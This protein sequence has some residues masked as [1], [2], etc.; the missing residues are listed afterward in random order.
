MDTTAPTFGLIVDPFIDFISCLLGVREVQAS[1]L[2][3]EVLFVLDHKARL[4][5]EALLGEQ[6][7][8]DQDGVLVGLGHQGLVQLLQHLV[9]TCAAD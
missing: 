7:V 6:A 4:H 9:R 3:F 2:T 1:G 8:G 5:G